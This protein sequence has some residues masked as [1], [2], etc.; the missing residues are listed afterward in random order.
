MMN[1]PE[2]SN[3]YRYL[4]LVYWGAAKDAP[5]IQADQAYLLNS[6]F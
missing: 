6:P 4:I 1:L 5:A 3:V 2:Y